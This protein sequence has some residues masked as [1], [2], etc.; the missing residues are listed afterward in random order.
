[1]LTGP[2]LGA[3]IEAARIKKKIAKNALAEA[4]GVKP[5]SIQGWVKNGRIDKS[6]LIDVMKYFSDVVGP[7]HWG[8][9]PAEAELLG[10]GS[11]FSESQS[12]AGGPKFRA[13]YFQSKANDFVSKAASHYETLALPEDAERVRTIIQNIHA[14]TEYKSGDRELSW[15]SNL[16]G[17]PVDRIHA[18]ANLEGSIDDLVDLAQE[19][20][21]KLG[22]PEK[23][24]TDSDPA[25]PS[26]RALIRYLLTDTPGLDPYIAYEARLKAAL[27]AIE[28]ACNEGRTT[29][30]TVHR[31]EEIV[32]GLP[33]EKR[34]MRPHLGLMPRTKKDREKDPEEDRPFWF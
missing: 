31:L 7:E 22:L 1:M 30:G 21:I 29:I 9:N 27:A 20:E 12:H 33:T 15:L 6:K 14:L 26:R 19:I 34:E 25:S 16:L 23:A 13:D 8:L 10:V 24:M 3:A 17:M 32:Q 2:E 18:I 5:P 11:G 4:F 28:K